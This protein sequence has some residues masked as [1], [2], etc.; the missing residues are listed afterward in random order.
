M[1]VSEDG[2]TTPQKWQNDDIH[3]NSG[4]WSAGFC[5]PSCCL[6]I[7]PVLHASRLRHLWDLDEPLWSQGTVLQMGQDVETFKWLQLI[8]FGGFK[9]LSV[10]VFSWIFDASTGWPWASTCGKCPA[11]VSPARFKQTLGSSFCGRFI[12]RKL[13]YISNESSPDPGL[14]TSWGWPTISMGQMWVTRHGNLREIEWFVSSFPHWGVAV[15]WGHPHWNGQSHR[16]L[17]FPRPLLS[18][19]LVIAFI[20]SEAWIILQGFLFMFLST[21]RVSISSSLKTQLPSWR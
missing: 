4:T 9:G 11:G 5:L 12:P 19:S 16:G 15:S 10:L 20:T 6:A 3:W 7:F 1:G 17:W 18:F 14:W 2:A 8:K 21:W 13:I